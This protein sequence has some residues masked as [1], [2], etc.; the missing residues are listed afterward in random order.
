VG[1]IYYGGSTAPIHVEDRA[2]AHL[3]VVIATKLRRNESFTMSWR[4]PDDQPPGRTTIWLH[5]AIPLKFV[6]DEPDPPAL[7]SAWIRELATSANSSGGIALVDEVLEP[8]N[9]DAAFPP[10]LSVGRVER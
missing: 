4:H 10:P 5:P 8:A 1:T 3:K 9:D 6:F 2:L 7:S